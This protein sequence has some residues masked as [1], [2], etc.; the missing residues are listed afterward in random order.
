MV[1]E[2]EI[3]KELGKRFE[4]GENWRRFLGILD[5]DRILEAEAS[6]QELK[7]SFFNDDPDWIIERGDLLDKSY[8][9]Y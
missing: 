5:E 2:A 6:S 3:K 8:L 9:K 7:K 1:E 4:F